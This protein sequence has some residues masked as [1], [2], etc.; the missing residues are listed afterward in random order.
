MVLPKRN[1]QISIRASD[2]V[3]LD[4]QYG[5]ERL[6]IT[7]LL[8][9]TQLEAYRADVYRGLNQF[10]NDIKTGRKINDFSLLSLA[11]SKLHEAGR[12][13]SLNLFG[14]NRHTVEKFFQRACSNWQRSGTEGYIPPIVQITSRIQHSLPL[15]FLPLFD[16]RKPKP[17]T[18]LNSLRQ[19]V[20]CF[21]VFSTIIARVFINPD[22]TLPAESRSSP[23]WSRTKLENLSGLPVRFFRHAGLPGAR[24]ERDFFERSDWIVL[25]GPWPEHSLSS[26]DFLTTLAG[27]LWDEI[28]QPDQPDQIHHFACHCNTEGIDSL[29]HSLFLANMQ[30][31]GLIAERRAPIRRLKGEFGSYPPRAAPTVRPLVFLNACGSTKMTPNGI[32]SF[33]E[34]FLFNVGNRGVIGT[35]T[36]IPDQ[37]AAEFSE[38]FYLNL[39]RGATLGMAI[40]NA[41]WTLLKRR[42]NPLGLLYSVYANPYATVRKP[43]RDAMSPARAQQ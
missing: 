40:F 22:P 34:M 36:R 3:I 10:L 5:T 12:V 8:A 20:A 26:N 27:Q 29:D 9:P 6:P 18:D 37:F 24:K 23:S 4:F 14:T 7:T 41:R 16:T 28:A 21:P 42:N 35:E 1:I 43:R 17:I 31:F 32:T 30:E 2:P 13:Q 33:P 39:V 19:T 38:Q 15:E 11:L 25:R